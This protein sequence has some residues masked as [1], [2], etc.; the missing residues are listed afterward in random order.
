MAFVKRTFKMVRDSSLNPL[1]KYKSYFYIWE[2]NMFL[3]FNVISL[4]FIWIN[5]WTRTS[6]VLAIFTILM[7]IPQ[8]SIFERDGINLK[9][10]HFQH[11]Q[12]GCMKFSFC[13]FSY[14]HMSFMAS[15]T[16]LTAFLWNSLNFWLDDRFQI[17]FYFH[18]CSTVLFF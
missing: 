17:Y 5:A 2:K 7:K 12:D 15:L 13:L 11:I 4:V 6:F 8:I 16:Q 18:Q 1:Y 3:F 14:D 9:H 10:W